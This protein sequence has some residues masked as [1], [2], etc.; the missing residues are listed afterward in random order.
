MSSGRSGC[1][2]D[3]ARARLALPTAGVPAAGATGGFGWRP[4]IPVRRSSCSMRAGSRGPGTTS[5]RTS[6]SRRPRTCT[7]PRSSRSVPPTSRR[8]SRWRS[9]ARRSRRSARS[10][11]RSPS[12]TP[13]ACTGRARC[14]GPI[15]SSVRSIHRRTSTTSTRA[16]VRRAATSPTPPSRRRSTTRKRAWRAS[17]PRPAP[18]SG[19]ARWRSPA[20]CSASRSRSTWSARATTRSRTA[21]S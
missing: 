18:A 9:S 19:A 14:T 11:S 1:V 15:D 7:R 21:G 12:G 13:T 5:R 2:P 20:R 17:P 8:S 4:R 16:S 6:R 10:R 3:G